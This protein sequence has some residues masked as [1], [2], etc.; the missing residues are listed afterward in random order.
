M[1]EKPDS[2]VGGLAILWNTCRMGVYWH[3]WQHGQVKCGVW[4]QRM[5]DVTNQGSMTSTTKF[6]W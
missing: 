4:A 6:K 2:K 5:R 1:E 3:G